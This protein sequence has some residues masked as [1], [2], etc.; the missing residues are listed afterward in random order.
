[1]TAKLTTGD[2]HNRQL[3]QKL[4]ALSRKLDEQENTNK[5][6]HRDEEERPDLRDK[7]S[8]SDF[9]NSSLMSE[10][11]ELTNRVLE[12]EGKD[13][14][15]IKLENHC[16]D[17]TE[18]LEI[19]S[20]KGQSLRAEVDTLNCRIIELEKLEDA[21]SKSKQE[22]CMLKSNLEKEKSVSKHL[23]EEL[24][25]L[26]TKIKEL[27]AMQNQMEK[28]EHTLKEDLT[29][30]KALTVILVDERK[31]MAEKMKQMEEKLQRSPGKVLAE[32][33]RATTV[34]EKLTGE[35]KK[36]LT[37]QARLEVK[38]Q[39]VTRD[40]E[41]L[42]EKLKAEEERSND[43]QMKVNMMKKKLQSMEVVER[44]FLKNKAKEEGFKMSSNQFQHEDNK[45]KDL[46][47][48]VERLKR[49]IKDMRLVEDGLLKTEDEFQ[50]LQKRYN[51]EQQRAKKLLEELEIS[52]N[53]LSKYQMAEKKDNN[54]EDLLYKCLKEEE[55]KSRHLTRD[56]EVLKEKLN[57][58]TGT[59]ES[60]SRL[61]KD[62]FILQKKLTQEETKNKDL[63]REMENLTTELGRYR[64]IS[65]NLQ[66]GLNGRHS[67]DFRVSSKEVQ[68][69]LSSS[70]PVEYK[71]LPLLERPVLN[72]KVYIEG[73]VEDESNYH[74]LPFTKCSTSLVNNASTLN[75]TMRHSFP[76]TKERQKPVVS[77]KAM[78]RQNGNYVQQGD[79][80]VRHPPGQPLHIK[81][82]PDHG[83]NTAMLEITSPGAENAH[84]YTS[85]AVIPTSGA[86]PKQQITIIQNAN[87]SPPKIKTPSSPDGLCAPDR[88]ASPVSMAA[89]SRV[90]TPDS[91]LCLTPERALS[92]IQIVSVTTGSP[93]RPQSTEFVE[94]VGSHAVFR[95]AQERQ[96]WQLERSSSSAPSVITTED[97]KI[98]IHLG[99]SYIQ[100]MNN[101]S[102]PTNPC[103]VSEQRHRSSGIF[104]GNSATK[105]DSKI[106][107]SL[108][109]TPNTSPTSRHP[110]ITVSSL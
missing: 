16:Q 75:K 55:A 8:R 79:V 26:K 68:T 5:I 48:E 12:I 54:Q 50:A 100:A 82:T 42:K 98:H 77:S 7:I 70:Q 96:N 14:E 56:L 65:K 13:E 46:T 83:Q 74:K 35:N 106:T 4:S 41:E 93:D 81:V 62:H 17:L 59:E 88:P 24:D 95:L 22:C 97:N 19:E 103:Y 72:G 51:N 49:K 9:R 66:P 78:T 69:T 30:L 43:L 28:T 87:M 105:G 110:H 63:A 101:T 89:F 94:V 37:S 60:I 53:E 25:M 45:V 11:E 27:E 102:H 21:F 80:V 2:T 73:N 86:P 6:F 15:L 57:E 58:F 32:Q 40:R 85:T 109:I 47:Q 52:K 108:T 10:V 3:R 23:S 34:T 99:N 90:M 107:S 33:D 20:T 84:S 91:S 18:M 1:M 39:S 61:K 71:G 104:S 31:T 44:E 76:I 36:G 29:K 92:P 64:H 67:T 38:I